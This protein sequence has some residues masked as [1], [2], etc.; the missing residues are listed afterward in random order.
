MTTIELPDPRDA[1]RRGRAGAP[2]EGDDDRRRLQG[3]R[4]RSSRTSRS[5][6]SAT[7]RTRSCCTPR[8]TPGGYRLYSP[9]TSRACARS[10]ACSATS[11]CRCA[12]SA[13]SSRPAATQDDGAEPPGRRRGRA[14]RVARRRASPCATARRAVLARGRARG[15]ARRRRARHGARGLRGHQGPGRARDVRYYDETEREII[16][17]V[18]RARA[19]RRRRAQ[20]ARVPHLRRPRGR[21]AAAD[22]RPGA[23]LAQP[24][25]PQGGARGAREP[26]GRRRRTSSTCC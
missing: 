11:S 14:T 24:R 23:A 4:S 13:R 1:E 21:A 22:P 26:R 8:R 2:P 18:D 16:R 20:P 19:L 7:S 6:R 10:C 5:P 3:A 9:A 25:A 15:D 12:S 17:A